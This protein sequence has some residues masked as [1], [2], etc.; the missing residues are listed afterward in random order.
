MQLINTCM[1]IFYLFIIYLSIC[2]P[3]YMFIYLSM[4]LFIFM[5]IYK[6]TSLSVY[7]P[8][9]H[10]YLS[11]YLFIYLST[12]LSIYLP[13]NFS[14]GFFG[15]ICVSLRQSLRDRNAYHVR[16]VDW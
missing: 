14:S 16:G 6:S 5:S 15:R 12:Y 2:L 11:I 13:I 7:L 10:A 1:S 8:I 3:V 9:S 4:Y